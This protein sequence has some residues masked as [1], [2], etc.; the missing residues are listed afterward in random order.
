M[1]VVTKE[2]DE[3][4]SVIEAR[5]LILVPYRQRALLHMKKFLPRTTALLLMAVWFSPV[6]ASATTDY[7]DLTVSVAEAGVQSY[8]DSGL[9]ND[10]P[11]LVEDFE[12]AQ[13][14]LSC[15]EWGNNCQ[16]VFT[17]EVGTFVN[18]WSGNF[19]P[20]DRWGGAGGVGTYASAGSITLTVSDD[21]DY[22]YVGFW[23]SAGSLGNDVEL[24]DES[25][26]VLARFTVNEDDD[27]PWDG[28]DTNN[29]D[30]QGVTAE[31]AYTH[32]PNHNV[33]DQYE[34]WPN[35]WE[36][37]EKYAFIHLRYPPGFRKVRFISSGNGFE[38]D[39]VTISTEVPDFVASETNTE[40]FNAYDLSTP[41][42]LLADPMSS[43]VQFPGLSLASGADEENAMICISQVEDADGQALPS[44]PNPTLQSNAPLTAGVASSTETNLQT[45]SG[46]R[47]T[48]ETF[49]SGIF[50]SPIVVGEA[51]NTFGSRFFRITVTPQTN[52]GTAGCTGNATDSEIVEI[53]FVNAIKRNSFGIQID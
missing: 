13:F 3:R 21:S 38:F 43:E 42:L 34:G 49:S 17:S 7:P 10:A 33:C 29:E 19:F 8:A 51:F 20:A 16:Q 11:V 5:K 2:Y 23:W 50:F 36:T 45:F 14:Q 40:T 9:V 46:P 53:R 25:D 44:P 48:I 35:C 4:L 47:S 37:W 27:T 41:G 31:D 24:L 39:N 26:I 12:N 6:S 18:D 1:P 22:R 52:V 28:D 15:D 30:L 32:N